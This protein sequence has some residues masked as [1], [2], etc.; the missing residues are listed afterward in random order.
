VNYSEGLSDAPPPVAEDGARPSAL[1]R[2][3]RRAAHAAS[4]CWSAA[5][6]LPGTVGGFLLL[7]LPFM[8]LLALIADLL[9]FLFGGVGRATVSWT[10]IF[11]VLG[12]VLGLVIGGEAVTVLPLTMGVTGLILG[13]TLGILCGPIVREMPEFM[14]REW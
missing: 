2:S 3:L 11:V 4:R 7:L 12:L 14:D 8:F 9:A 10:L 5:R 6:A 13:F 1:K